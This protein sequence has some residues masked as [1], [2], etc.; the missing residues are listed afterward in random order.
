MWVR[1][2]ARNGDKK[3]RIEVLETVESKTVNRIVMKQNGGK[4]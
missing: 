4:E 1:Y 3:N 2:D